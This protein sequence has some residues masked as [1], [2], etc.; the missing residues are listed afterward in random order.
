MIQPYRLITEKFPGEYSKYF[1]NL[2]PAKKYYFLG[3]WQ[4]ASYYSGYEEKIRKFFQPKD[5]SI[6]QTVLAKEISQ[7]SFATVSLH[8]R[9]GDYLTAGFIKPANEEYI[10][11]AIKLIKSKLK[12]PFFYIFTDDP[13]WVKE[14]LSVRSF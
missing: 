12:N 10:Y 13:Q 8:I 7:S 2:N 11:N 4:N 14:N 6:F 3:F 9:R 1:E 5:K